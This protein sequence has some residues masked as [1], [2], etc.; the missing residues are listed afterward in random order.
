MKLQTVRRLS[1]EYLKLYMYSVLKAHLIST[2]IYGF[3]K[4][5][6]ECLSKGLN[7]RQKD[8][9]KR[10]GKFQQI[11]FC[12]RMCVCVESM[13]VCVWFVEQQIAFEKQHEK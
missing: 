1:Q 5:E 12:L 9:R 2:I 4:H 11:G 3:D 8:K 13:C 7:G 6:R 10:N